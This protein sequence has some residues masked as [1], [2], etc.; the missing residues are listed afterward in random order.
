VV[1]A[2]VVVINNQKNKATKRAL[3]EA[4]TLHPR[5]LET[6]QLAALIGRNMIA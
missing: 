1:V 4:A 3:P 5:S 6:A 2:V